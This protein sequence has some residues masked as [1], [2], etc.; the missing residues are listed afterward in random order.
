MED[1]P[2]E[3]VYVSSVTIHWPCA[4]ST[5]LPPVQKPPSVILPRWRW[6]PVARFRRGWT[7]Q[8]A[9]KA[10]SIGGNFRPP[11]PTVHD[12]WGTKIGIGAGSDWFSI[13]PPCR[14]SGTPHP[15]FRLRCALV[16]QVRF[17]RDGEAKCVKTFQKC[18]K[19]IQRCPVLEQ[20]RTFTIILCV[21]QS[22]LAE[23]VTCNFPGNG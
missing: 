14:K 8:I 17:R 5:L 11:L 21:R 2:V 18:L 20:D 3:T 19:N 1:L 4:A 16:R 22:L 15:A 7:E 23:L 6:Q 9:E 13:S 12:N 10:H